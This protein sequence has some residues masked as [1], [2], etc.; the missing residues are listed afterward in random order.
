MEESFL[1]ENRFDQIKNTSTIQARFENVKSKRVVG[2]SEQDFVYR[3]I[4][5]DENPK[6]GLH[7]KNPN[8]GMTIEGHIRNGSRPDFKGSQFISTTTDY[9]V[10]R[11]YAEKRLF[12]KKCG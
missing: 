2:D 10:A 5:P 11:E 7:A 6:N 12:S 4:R 9:N 8:R 3:V 1:Y